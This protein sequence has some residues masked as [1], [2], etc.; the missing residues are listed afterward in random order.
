MRQTAAPGDVGPDIVLLEELT[1][2]EQRR[3]VAE[4]LRR[5]REAH[6]ENTTLANWE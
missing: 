6:P 4:E 1:R 3:R 5:L 2:L